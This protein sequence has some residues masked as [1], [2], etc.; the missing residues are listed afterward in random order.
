M[1]ISGLVTG[2]TPHIARAR[3]LPD[4]L[5]LL[6]VC[7]VG[8]ITSCLFVGTAWAWFGPSVEDPYLLEAP[9]TVREPHPSQ[10]WFWL[11]SRTAIEL[12]NRPTR[13][14]YHF[15]DAVFRP[16]P[17]DYIQREFLRQVAHHDDRA[18]LMDK[19]KGK[20]VRLLEFDAVVGLWVRLGEAQPGK[21]ETV[22]VRAVIEVDGNRYEASDSHPFR[23]GDKPSPAS[24]PMK[25]LVESLVNQMVHF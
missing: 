2:S 17:F 19:L 9:S 7:A 8:L 1:T 12:D 5:F 3:V 15:G 22:R 14:G 13:D 20:T 25:A 24:I 10:T 16:R 23:Y 21:W 4:M 6:R 11:D 18:E